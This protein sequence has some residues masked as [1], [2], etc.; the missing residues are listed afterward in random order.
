MQNNYEDKY[1]G[2]KRI[3]IVEPAGETHTHVPL[4]KVTFEDKSSAIYSVMMLESEGVVTNGPADLTAYRT[5]RMYELTKH[6]LEL[7]LGYNIEVGEVAYLTQMVVASVN[8]NLDTAETYQW[9][10]EY[11]DKR[12]MVQVDSVILEK[13]Q[14]KTLKDVGIGD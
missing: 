6:I 4:L 3:K 9:G 5:A 8:Q 12:T 7:M 10:V 14:R 13:G 1:L 2:D 11:L